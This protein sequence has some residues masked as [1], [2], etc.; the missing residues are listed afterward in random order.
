MTEKINLKAPERIFDSVNN[1][2]YIRSDLV[3]NVLSSVE[4]SEMLDKKDDEIKF[5][6][7]A[8]EA[9]LKDIA[10]FK[11]QR[12]QLLECFAAWKKYN[13][14]EGDSKALTNAQ[15]L[16]NKLYPNFEYLFVEKND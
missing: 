2:V 4:I 8:M 9:A 15:N 1:C 14:L 12:N 7:D 11:N 5:L 3:S 10:F 16:T 13:D 6:K